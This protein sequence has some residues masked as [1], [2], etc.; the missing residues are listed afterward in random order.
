MSLVS[1]ERGRRAEQD[2]ARRLTTWAD[3]LYTFARRGLGHAGVAD[4]VVTAKPGLP[5]WPFTVSVKSHRV[6]AFESLARMLVRLEGDKAWAWWMELE[7]P[8]DEGRAARRAAAWLVWRSSAG[9]WLLS[10]WSLGGLSMPP[11]LMLGPTPPAGWPRFTMLFDSVLAGVPI[12]H[13]VA[14]IADGWGRST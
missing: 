10:C 12:D 13:V 2:V 4:L 5:P 8:A 1:L 11:R 7:G 9:P 14:A 3:G 6:R